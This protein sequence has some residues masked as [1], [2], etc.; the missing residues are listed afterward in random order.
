LR[1]KGVYLALFILIL[2][3]SCLSLLLQLPSSLFWILLLPGLLIQ[4]HLYTGLFITAHDAM[5]GTVAPNHRKMNDILGA[6]S[7]FLYALFNF[8]QL[9]DKHQYHH[10]FPG[11]D[12]DPDFHSEGKPGFWQWYSRFLFNYLR[13]PQLVGMAII[14]NILH[15]L[16]QI[17]LQNL[18][19][20]WVLPSL[21]STL[22]LFYFGTFLPHRRT[23]QPFPDEHNAHSLGY[24]R[25]VSLVSCYHF[26]GFHHKH[27][28]KPGVAWWQLAKK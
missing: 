4:T 20:F 3:V 27:H 13:W 7:V 9:K 23:E 11:S 15:H 16:L 10:D 25:L 19:L 12:K 6:V 5:H 8:K 24:S 18:L 14:F 26:G 17:P 1:N 21:L 2:W 28:L 22:Q